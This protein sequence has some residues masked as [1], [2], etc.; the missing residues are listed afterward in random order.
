MD[1]R[2]DEGVGWDPHRWDP[3]S[4]EAS[5]ASGGMRPLGLA[6]ILDGMFRLL[7]SHW[8]AYLLALGVILVPV[9]LVTGYLGYRAPDTTGLMAQLGTPGDLPAMLAS[10]SDFAGIAALIGVIVAVGLLV[11]PLT[12][13]TACRIAATGHEGGEPEPWSSLRSALRRYGALV[14]VNLLIFLL[15]LGMLVPGSALL[16]FGAVAE[17]PG[18]VI[19]G[20]LAALAG[21]LAA[22]VL[23]VMFALA[24]PAVVVERA[25]PV[26]ALRRSYRLVR[27][28]FWPVGGTL[29]LA[30]VIGALVG[31]LLAVPFSLPGAVVGERLGAVLSTA[32][33][34]LAAILTT[35]LSAN[36]QTLLYYDARVR[37]EGLDLE[38]QTERMGGPS[39]WDGLPG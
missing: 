4:Q 28:R 25:G 7:V 15:P 29:F 11:T 39:G 34:A 38:R 32:G 14:G 30:L 20:V 36:A 24:Y 33:A 35:P 18:V 6:E 17:S 37:R 21:L 2:S 9:N 13:G 1:R 31:S 16:G 27:G 5:G 19:A 10:L 3:P 23:L 26:A 12:T 22:V 8:R